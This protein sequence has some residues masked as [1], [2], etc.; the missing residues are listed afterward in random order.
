MQYE[1]AIDLKESP[2]KGLPGDTF[3]FRMYVNDQDAAKFDGY[4][5]LGSVYDDPSTYGDLILALGLHER[6]DALQTDIET[7][8]DDIRRVNATIGDIKTTMMS[9][10]EDV[11]NIKGQ[12]A[13]AAFDWS[14]ITMILAFIAAIGSIAVAILSWRRTQGSARALSEK[15][16]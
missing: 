14:V 4:W 5:P 9:V 15:H 3:G 13:S 6:L 8:N 16:S 1:V 2:L 12:V 11:E 7:L 10:L